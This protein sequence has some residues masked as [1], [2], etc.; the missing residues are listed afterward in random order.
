MILSSYNDFN[1]A[2]DS[3]LAISKIFGIVSNHISLMSLMISFSKIRLNSL[4]ICWHIIIVLY[5]CKD[6]GYMY[7]CMYIFM[8]VCVI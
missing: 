7:I 3:N 5:V 2:F 4:K 1:F 8:Y 6:Y